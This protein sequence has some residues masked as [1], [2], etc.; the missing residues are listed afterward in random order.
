MI[1]CDQTTPLICAVG[2]RSALTV[3]GVSGSVGFVGN[4]SALAEG[5]PTMATDAASAAED[6]KTALLRQGICIAI[7][8]F[9]EPRLQTQLQTRTQRSSGKCAAARAGPRVL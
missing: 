4:V 1:T 2:S 5:T 8:P 7:L 3:T 6:R 9:S